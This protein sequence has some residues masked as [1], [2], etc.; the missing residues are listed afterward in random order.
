LDPLINAE[1]ILPQGDG[2]DLASVME[3]KRA[4]DGSSIGRRNKNPLLDSRIYIIKFPDGEMKDVGYNILAEHLFSQIDKDGNQFRLFS[5]IIGHRRNGNAVD[6]EEQMR[7]SEKIKVKKK[8]LSG[9]ALEVE[10]CDGGTAWIQLKTMK[11]LNAVEV[12]EYALANQIL[13]EPAFDWWVHD[14]IRHKKRLIKLS[15]KRFLHPQYKYGICVPRNIG[16]AIKFDLE[17]GNKFWE[18]AIAK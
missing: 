15:Q 6:K 3:R 10:W 13:H 9:W 14:V 16:E 2:I 4:H 1:I 8:S 7:I 18:T 11:E 5:G 17:N 12:D